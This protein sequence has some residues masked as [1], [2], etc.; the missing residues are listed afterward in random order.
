MGD[1]AI[2]TY[3]HLWYTVWPK[4]MY[5][6]HCLGP[7]EL[8]REELDAHAPYVRTIVVSVGRRSAY[9]SRAFCFVPIPKWP[10]AADNI[11]RGSLG[12]AGGTCRPTGTSEA[13]GGNIS[14]TPSS[15]DLEG[16]SSTIGTLGRN[17]SATASPR[18]L[19]LLVI[20]GA[21]LRTAR[22]RSHACSRI[23]LEC[24]SLSRRSSSQR[25]HISICRRHSTMRGTSSQM[26]IRLCTCSLTVIC[27][28]E[29]RMLR[30]SQPANIH[31]CKFHV[32]SNSAIRLPCPPFAA[33]TS[34][35]RIRS[36]RSSMVM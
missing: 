23:A 16:G 15:S 25:L 1:G 22:P 19:A 27:S 29:R 18:D 34:M 4:L 24:R 7:T 3:I 5:K 36:F 2:H 21:A 30:S 17:S 33:R 35:L 12:S 28:M 14:S 26:M 13:L 32:C 11:R 20:T 31:F 8:A 10:N 9:F 6:L